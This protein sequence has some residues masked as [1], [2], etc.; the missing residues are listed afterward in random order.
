MLLQF[1]SPQI[2]AQITFA[3]LILTYISFCPSD[4]TLGIT[5]VMETFQKQTANLE[6]RKTEYWKGLECHLAPPYI[7]KGPQ[8]AASPALFT[9]PEVSETYRHLGQNVHPFDK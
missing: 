6:S 8:K 2:L 7:E 3:I 9:G 4:K 5:E 1:F